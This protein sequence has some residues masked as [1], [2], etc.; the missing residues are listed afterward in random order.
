MKVPCAKKVPRVYAM[1]M[2]QGSHPTC[3]ADTATLEANPSL[4]TKLGYSAEKGLAPVSL[5]VRF[6]RI[7]VQCSILFGT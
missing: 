2:L 4:Y 5:T 7:R 3:L 6:P 1:S